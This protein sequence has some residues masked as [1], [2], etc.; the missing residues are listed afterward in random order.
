VEEYDKYAAAWNELGKVYLSQKDKDKAR[1][2]FQK[3]IS[4]DPQ[5]TSPYL[6]LATLELELQQYEAAANTAGKLLDLDSSITYASFVQ[7]VANFDLNRLDEAEK[8][9]LA[10][11]K[12]GDDSLPQV[13]ALLAQIFLEKQ[14]Y[15][16]AAAQ[17][18]TYLQKAPQGQFAEQMKKNLD[19]IQNAAKAETP[20][21]AA[22]SDSEVPPPPPIGSPAPAQQ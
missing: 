6:S 20:A 4:A 3:A 22:G 11:K 15:T 1:D 14:D 7:A 9:A 8:G 16:R 2:A 21:E 5:Y 17:M 12:N 10:V 19:E 13:H 18:R